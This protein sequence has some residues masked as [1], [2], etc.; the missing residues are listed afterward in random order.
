MG[1]F[2][3]FRENVTGQKICPIEHLQSYKRLGEQVYELHV[4]LTECENPRA[5]AFLQAAKSLQTMADALLGD[6]FSGIDGKPNA[7]PI[8][9]HDQAD[10]WY[11]LIPD[12][13]IAARQEASFQGSSNL[14]LPIQLGTQM[15]G[16][17]PCPVEHLAGLRRAAAGMEEM[18][19]VDIQIAR[20][21]GEEYKAA[22]LL[23]EEAR[24]RKQSGD[25]IVGILSEGRRVSEET[26]EDAEQ[27]YWKALSSY[28]LVAQGLKG[29]DI[30]KKENTL[31][32]KTC[33]LDSKNIW[34]VTSQIAK[35]EV[36]RAGEWEQAEEDLTEHWEQYIMRE[37]DR[38]YETTVEELLQAGKIK[39]TSYWYCCPFPSVYQVIKTPVV[40]LGQEIPLHHYFVY[41]YGDDGA[42]ARFITNKEFGTADERK[43]CDD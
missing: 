27:Q 19:Q 18:V 12:L 22:I 41:E 26:H 21:K 28:M 32:R 37:D 35:S 33:K 39:E 13:I 7:V 31:N 8:I 5:L 29:S 20:T 2:N 25:A 23:Y 17:S 30:L 40:I 9:T 42:P 1:L 15:E 14:A 11:G 3:W 24:T 38:T 34:K 6:A 36:K 43:Y 10:V 4:E 16:P